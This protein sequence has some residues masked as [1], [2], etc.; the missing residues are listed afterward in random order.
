MRK[1]VLSLAVLAMTSV[2]AACNDQSGPPPMGAAEVKVGVMTMKSQSVLRSTTLPGRVTSSA[3]AEV[4]P[5]VEGILTEKQFRETSYVNKGDVLYKIDAAKFEAAKAASEASVKKAEAT[6]EGAK[7]TMAR[8]EKL[9]ASKN[10][11]QQTLEEYKTAVLQ[12][13]ADLAAAKADLQTA[14]ID[15]DNTTIRAPISG[16]IGYS[17]VSVGSLVTANQTDALA[18]IEQIDPIYVD[19]VDSSANLLRLRAE[20]DAGKIERAEDGPPS[21]D[22]TLE[23]GQSYSETGKLSM[24]EFSVSE[25]TGTFQ[26][27]ST[28]SNPTR[29]L[30]PGMFVRAKVTVGATKNAYLV[31]QRAV[32]HD[33][34][35]N[36]IAY[37]V[38]SE[39][40]AEARPLQTIAAI[41]QNWL[42]TDDI[43]DGDQLIV[44]GFQ[45]FSAGADVTAVPVVI[46]ENG[47]TRDAD[48]AADTSAS[49]ATDATDKA[50]TE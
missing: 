22:L 17:N 3:E 12:A 5:Q 25:T 40:K 10:A 4:R 8:T 18:T 1:A 45:K 37:F 15:L 20:R 29:M 46:D 21:V 28:F 14:Q 38:S 34:S 48:A 19:L 32:S 42:V 6:L 11:S 24:A 23:T 41:D 30:M 9:V 27:R 50:E 33:S 13:E 16:L 2:L 26:V 39:G 43:Q 36:A 44:D 31:P 47:V 35:G 49:E 7:Q